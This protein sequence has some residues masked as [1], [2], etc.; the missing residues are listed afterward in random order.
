MLWVV[1]FFLTLFSIDK[2]LII[3]LKN[4]KVEATCTHVQ[5]PGELRQIEKAFPRADWTG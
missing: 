5:L 3:F 4:K 2:A 1:G